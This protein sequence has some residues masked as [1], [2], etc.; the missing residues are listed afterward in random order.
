MFVPKMNKEMRVDVGEVRM[1]QKTED[2]DDD[3]N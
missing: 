2:D 3:D 1:K